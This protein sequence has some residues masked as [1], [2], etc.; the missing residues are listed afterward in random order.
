MSVTYRGAA[1]KVRVGR[2]GLDRRII[3]K[4]CESITPRS[5]WQSGMRVKPTVLFSTTVIQAQVGSSLAEVMDC[6]LVA[7][8]SNRRSPFV[9]EKILL[10]AVETSARLGLAFWSHFASM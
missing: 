2:R 4:S 1:Q 10:G 9:E 6:M 7:N 3:A 5:G 8:E